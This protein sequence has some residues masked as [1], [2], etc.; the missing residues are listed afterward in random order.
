MCCSVSLGHYARNTWGQVLQFQ[1]ANLIPRSL[2]NGLCNH[3]YTQTTGWVPFQKEWQEFLFFT[4]KQEFLF[5][6]KKTR[7]FVFYN[8]EKNVWLKTYQLLI[9]ANFYLILWDCNWPQVTE[10]VRGR[11]DEGTI[12]YLLS[13]GVHEI[14]TVLNWK[15]LPHCHWIFV[16]FW[17]FSHWNHNYIHACTSLSYS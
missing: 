15:T 16:S 5:F 12:Q 6:T 17:H 9:S 8:T 1:V 7:V 2:L 13:E 10:T 11:A 4:K 14:Y 3:G